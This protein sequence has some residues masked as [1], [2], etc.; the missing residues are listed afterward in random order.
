VTRGRGDVVLGLGSVAFAALYGTIA[1]QIPQSL[2][3]D[4]VGATGFPNVLAIALALSGS[5]LILRAVKRTSGRGEPVAWPAH[6]RAAGLLSI[7]V[8]YIVLAPVA[9]YPLALAV[10]IGAVAAYA[11]ARRPLSILVTSAAGGLLFWLAF[12]KLLGVAM[13]LGLWQSGG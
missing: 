9:G 1:A 12:A 11:G 4:A 6:V 13:P 7:L 2:L 10:L 3:S 5:L 8:A